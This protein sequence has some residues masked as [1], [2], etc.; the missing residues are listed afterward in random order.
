MHEYMAVPTGFIAFGNI[1]SSNP[2][3][4]YVMLFGTFDAIY[5]PITDTPDINSG[6]FCCGYIHST[7][8]QV[9]SQGF[10]IGDNL[11][12]P[13]F[14]VQDFAGNAQGIVNSFIKGSKLTIT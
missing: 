6:L 3:E 12:G 13:F 10:N 11:I 5:T 2:F 4:R 14:P 9:L 7:L 1:I 8:T